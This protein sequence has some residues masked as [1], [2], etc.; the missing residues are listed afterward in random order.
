MHRV[1]SWEMSPVTPPMGLPDVVPPVREN[2]LKRLPTRIMFRVPVD[3]DSVGVK[4]E[5]PA[6]GDL[7]EVESSGCLV[8]PALVQPGTDRIITRTIA[9]LSLGKIPHVI[10]NCQE[11]VFEQAMHSNTRDSDQ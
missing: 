3:R 6:R 7:A 9:D 4:R 2:L 11:S 10:E 1:R 5:E 8:E